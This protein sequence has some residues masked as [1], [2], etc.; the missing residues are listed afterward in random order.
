MLASCANIYAVTKR[1]TP[2]ASSSLATSPA[3]GCGALPLENE[4][5]LTVSSVSRPA[6]PRVPS[7]LQPL[8]AGYDFEPVTLGC[9][10]A[11]VFRLRRNAENRLFLKCGPING[12]L[13]EEA[14]RLEWL[15]GR[16][17][18][19]SVIAFVAEED[20]EFLLIQALIGQDG[21][22]AGRDDPEAVVVGLAQELRVWHSQPVAGCPFDQGVAVQIQRARFRLHNGLVDE[23]DFDEERR[24]RS[25]MELLEE[26]D[27]ARPETEEKVLTHGDPCV[28]NVIF[29]G[30]ECVGLIDCGRAGVADR[31]QDIALAARSINRN[32]G[33]KWVQPFFEHYGILKVDE[34]KLAFYRLLDEFF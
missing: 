12:G 23:G 14:D 31:Y 6:I 1:N 4:D 2:T 9:S 34:R 24:G 32:L 5:S 13:K 28:P 33:S 11:C 25:A 19:P 15:S 22:E 16:V 10:S 20:R 8:V 7:A 17:R 3:R 29:K 30:A 18:V 27:R 26:L 21:T